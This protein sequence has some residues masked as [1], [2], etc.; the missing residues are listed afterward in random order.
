MEISAL[1]D[2]TLSKVMMLALK[3]EENLAYAIPTFAY[4][5]NKK[6][7]PRSVHT[8]ANNLS[9]KVDQKKV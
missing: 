8:E 1:I 5:L 6:L 7:P 3:L 4:C 9:M 2:P